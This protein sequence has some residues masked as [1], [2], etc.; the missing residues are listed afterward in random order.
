M[1][2]VE[3]DDAEYSALS[4]GLSDMPGFGWLKGRDNKAKLA[5]IDAERAKLKNRRDAKSKEMD[6]A[7][8]KAKADIEGGTTMKKGTASNDA[9]DS[10]LSSDDRKV[11][12]KQDKERDKFAAAFQA[13]LAGKKANAE[14]RDMPWSVKHQAV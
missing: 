1:Q 7:W 8:A 14:H 11:N 4:E 10:A 2:L 5:K 13:G 6:A 12:A 3:L 9:W